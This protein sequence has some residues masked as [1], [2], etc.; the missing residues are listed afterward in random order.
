VPQYV[1][2]IPQYPY[3]EQHFSA[4]HENPDAGPQIPLGDMWLLEEDFAD[5]TFVPLAEYC[6]PELPEC[7]DEW[8]PVEP[9]AYDMLPILIAVDIEMDDVPAPEP[10]PVASLAGRAPS[11][12]CFQFGDGFPEN[13]AI[14]T[15]S[16][17]Y[18]RALPWL[19]PALFQFRIPF[20]TTNV[21]W[22]GS[23]TVLIANC[24][25]T[26]P[27][28][29]DIHPPWTVVNFPS[30]ITYCAANDPCVVNLPSGVTYSFGA[31]S[32]F[33]LDPGEAF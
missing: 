3:E 8:P 26:T 32:L 20:W 9:G 4:A 22:I 11:R 5:E 6:F 15:E 33:C 21:S 16:R 30:C 28:F 18:R 2:P 24:L 1:S 19:N 10:P 12:I 13:S 14:T 31:A 29:V 25:L 27:C 17:L 7:I 23:T